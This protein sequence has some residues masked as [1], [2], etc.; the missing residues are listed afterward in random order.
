MMAGQAGK[1]LPAAGSIAVVPECGFPGRPTA[2]KSSRAGLLE[3]IKGC[4]VAVD[5]VYLAVLIR[6]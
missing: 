3:C 1:G 4:I 5:W 2:R 6:Q